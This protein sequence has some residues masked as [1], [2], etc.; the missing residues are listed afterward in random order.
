MDKEFLQKLIVSMDYKGCKNCKNQISPLRM[1]EWAEQGG[2][3]QVHF[4]CPK[5]NKKVEN[6]IINGEETMNNI[7]DEFIRQQTEYKERALAEII[8][9]YDFIVGSIECKY[10]LMEIL[11][12]GATIVCSPHIEDPT[13][14]YAIKKFDIRDLLK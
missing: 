9:K 12:E 3:G 1:C 4:I 8:T 5:W 2:D 10:R 13:M 7:I 14:I 11:P 6:N